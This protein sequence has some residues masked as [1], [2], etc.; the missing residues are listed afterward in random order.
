[1][2]H[3]LRRNKCIHPWVTRPTPQETGQSAFAALAEIVVLLQADPETDWGAVNIDKLRDHLV[4]MDLLTRK[5][6]VTRILRP[7][8]ARFEVRGSRVSCRPS[9][10]WFPPM[11]RSLPVKQAGVLRQKK[12]RMVSH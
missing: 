5:A 8:G 4:D 2:R 12:W 7:D 1:M 10:Q 3:P 6:E 11:H 9:T